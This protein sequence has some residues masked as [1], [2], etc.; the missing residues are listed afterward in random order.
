MVLK[1]RAPSVI[2][3]APCRRESGAA[4]IS[5]VYEYARKGGANPPSLALLLDL[6]RPEFGQ[7]YFDNVTDF[8]MS[9][10][11]IDAFIQRFVVGKDDE[12]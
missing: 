4:D 12:C 11:E 9:D 2:R 8:D 3:F 10:E 6:V 1:V 5:H 7:G